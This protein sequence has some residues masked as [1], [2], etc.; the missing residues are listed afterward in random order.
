MACENAQ[1]L[2]CPCR[3]WKTPS[4]VEDVN[5]VY[6]GRPARSKHLWGD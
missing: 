3:V 5:D 1:R 2:F 4:A 6:P